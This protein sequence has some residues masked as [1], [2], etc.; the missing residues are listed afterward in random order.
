MKKSLWRLLLKAGLMAGASAAVSLAFWTPLQK[1]ERSHFENVTK[2][3][4]RSLQADIADDME[5]RLLA[6]M[7]LAGMLSPK[8]SHHG[9]DHAEMFV[10]DNRG[11]VAVQWVDPDYRVRWLVTRPEGDPFRSVLLRIDP[12]LRNALAGIATRGDAEARL[13]LA[14]SF[15]NGKVGRWVIVPSYSSGELR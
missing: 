4:A 10:L 13:G 7:R 5:P 14:V 12:A 6:Q 2:L 15:P 3:S 11:Y 8:L 9:R 1:K